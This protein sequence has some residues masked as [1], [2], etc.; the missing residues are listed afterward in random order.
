MRIHIYI[1]VS[2]P[3]LS[4]FSVAGRYICMGHRSVV[5]TV[6]TVCTAML[7]FPCFPLC[8]LPHTPYHVPPHHVPFPV[9]FLPLAFD[10][11]HTHCCHTCFLASFIGFLQPFRPL[12]IPQPS[13]PHHAGF[14]ILL[15][16]TVVFKGTAM[17]HNG[18]NLAHSPSSVRE[19]GLKILKM[20]KTF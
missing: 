12:G 20:M 14:Q 8:D 16:Q 19:Y 4:N 1:C 18:E 9:L 3:G 10:L 7:F 11:Y 2:K 15:L 17:C 13:P 5:C 6:C